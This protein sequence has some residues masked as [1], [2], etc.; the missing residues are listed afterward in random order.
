MAV[1]A[2][3]IEKETMYNGALR[4]FGNTYHYVTDTGEPFDD[5][6]AA[7]QI[8]DAEKAV[9]SPS[10]AFKAWRSWGPT[11]GPAFENVMRDE[12]VLTGN[13]TGADPAGL[14]AEVCSLIVWPLPRSA[15]T[16]RKRWLRKFL[17]Q[18]VGDTNLVAD[19]IEGRQALPA[20]NKSELI[21][22]Y[23]SVVQDL[24]TFGNYRLCTAQGDVPNGDPIVRDYLYTRQIGQ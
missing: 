9:T 5:A 22:Q 24:V 4:R 18:A 6:L 2:V 8:S 23:A 20:A 17:R 14:Y 21:N 1:F 13:G 16:N 10:V 11:D 3:Y 12:G 19:V 7:Q 15:A